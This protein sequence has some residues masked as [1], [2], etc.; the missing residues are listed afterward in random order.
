MSRIRDTMKSHE[1]VGVIEVMGNKCG[2]IALYA[3]IA[4]GAEHIIIPEVEF[5][6]DYI[7]EE[8]LASRIKGKMTSIVLIAEGAGKGEAVANYMRAKAKLDA[9]AIVLG[10]IQRGGAPT[11][12]DRLRATSMG[13][14]AVRLLEKGIGNRVVGI[15]DNKIIDEDID[16]ALSKEM[17]FRKDLYEEF[18]IMS[19]NH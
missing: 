9:K 14:R 2:D 4:G 19:E 6:I 17:V 15:R 8:I 13:V 10:Y 7:C 16:E 12:A 1:R 18:N 11:A 5:D 3:G